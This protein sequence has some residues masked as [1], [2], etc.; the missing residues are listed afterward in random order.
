VVMLHWKCYSWKERLL[1]ISEPLGLLTVAERWLAYYDMKVENAR[2]HIQQQLCNQPYLL[3]GECEGE[4]RVFGL[5]LRKIRDLFYDDLHMTAPV[6]T[7]QISFLETMMLED[8]AGLGCENIM[9]LV[10][11]SVSE[12]H[13]ARLEAR[14]RMLRR[15]GTQGRCLFIRHSMPLLYNASVHEELIDQT[16]HCLIQNHTSTGKVHVL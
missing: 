2:Y 7:E 13:C 6:N 10:D 4:F 14:W 16:V 15:N 12:D 11:S 3:V 8:I 1:K 9:F 5:K